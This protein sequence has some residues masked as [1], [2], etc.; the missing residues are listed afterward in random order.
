[1]WQCLFVHLNNILDTKDF[2][3][4]CVT[5][6]SET[7]TDTI[8]AKMARDTTKSKHWEAFVCVIRLN[9]VAYIPE[10]AFILV[11]ITEIV[12]RILRA[13]VTVGGC[14]INGSD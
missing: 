7:V 13:W 8:N 1:M 2:R 4:G 3:I 10:S 11:V 12:K 14:V 6:H 5:V 9:Y